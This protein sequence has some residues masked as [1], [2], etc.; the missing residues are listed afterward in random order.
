MPGFSGGPILDLG[1]PEI[2]GG[3]PHSAS[4]SATSS[5]SG[6]STGCAAGTARR[7][8]SIQVSA[9]TGRR[10]DAAMRSGEPGDVV[11]VHTDIAT[12]QAD[13]R[14]HC[15]PEQI[16]RS[17]EAASSAGSIVSGQAHRR[18]SVEGSETSLDEP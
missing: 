4:S 2:G 8:R 13:P 1:A 6:G 10:S 12:R 17:P 7:A 11:G 15:A 14:N 18:T 5:D 16:E 3:D 9:L